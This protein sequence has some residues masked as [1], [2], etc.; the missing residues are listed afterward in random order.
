M[1]HTYTPPPL[2]ESY[3]KNNAADI[4][5]DLDFMRQMYAE[6]RSLNHHRHEAF[7]GYSLLTVAI[8]FPILVIIA[9][10]F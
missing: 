8:G 9:I 6:R 7:I 2:R 4:Q 1:K 3:G 10:L 5:R